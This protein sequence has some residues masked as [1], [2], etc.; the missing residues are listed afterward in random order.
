VPI[1]LP[2]G[3]KDV[4][5]EFAPAGST[6]LVPARPPPAS[7]SSPASTLVTA[8]SKP[9]LKNYDTGKVVFVLPKYFFMTGEFRYVRKVQFPISISIKFSDLSLLLWSLFRSVWRCGRG[10]GSAVR[11]IYCTGPWKLAS[12]PLYNLLTSPMGAHVHKT[13][14]GPLI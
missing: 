14:S 3:G 9:E 4:R 13:T 6:P 1:Y 8:L 10:G 11:K 12:T 2:S 7:A 5:K